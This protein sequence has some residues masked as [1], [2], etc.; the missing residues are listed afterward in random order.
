[1]RLNAINIL[2]AIKEK[3]LNKPHVNVD[4]NVKKLNQ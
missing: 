3:E 2:D 1:M 4:N